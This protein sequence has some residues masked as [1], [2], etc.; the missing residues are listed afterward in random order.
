MPSQQE[1]KRRLLSDFKYSYDEETFFKL[2]R[3]E[4]GLW[5]I[6]AMLFLLRKAMERC[7]EKKSVMDYMRPANPQTKKEQEI[8]Q[9]LVR[10]AR[11]EAIRTRQ[12]K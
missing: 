12:K 5:I 1:N 10:K 9:E 6:F 8:S 3:F 11:E 7:G 4:V 2:T